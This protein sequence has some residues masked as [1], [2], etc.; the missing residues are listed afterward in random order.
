MD[1]VVTWPECF[2]GQALQAQQ[3]PGNDKVLTFQ[4]S[5][6]Y[7]LE[8]SEEIKKARYDE[9]IGEQQIKEVKGS[10]LPQLS[11]TGSFDYYPSLP[12]QIFPGVLVGQEGD[13][14]VQF[15]KDFNVSGGI[16]LTQLLFNKSFF[17]GLEA[18]KSTQDLYRL[19]T[20]MAEEE[21]IY[22][23][24]ASYLQILQTQEQFETIE[25]NLDRLEQLKKFCSCST[26][27]T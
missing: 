6:Q 24:S 8:Q 26:R 22:N 13:I 27:T 16:Q 5:I 17:V 4:E 3:I 21:V 12:T 23:V 25:A 15:G 2:S 14:P 11:A 10:G 19:R 7:A 1:A 20:E 9:E 18:A